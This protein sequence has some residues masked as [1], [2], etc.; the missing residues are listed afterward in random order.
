VLVC[1]VSPGFVQFLTSPDLQPRGVRARHEKVS[2]CS[3]RALI[4]LVAASLACGYCIHQFIP[5]KTSDFKNE[6][7]HTGATGQV[8]TGNQHPMVNRD[9]RQLPVEAR[10][11][12]V[13]PIHN[14]ADLARIKELLVRAGQWEHASLWTGTSGRRKRAR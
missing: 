3:F 6:A 8:R 2:A 7:S 14:D 1:T 10:R 4:L 11:N 9:K 13:R 5:K 12:G